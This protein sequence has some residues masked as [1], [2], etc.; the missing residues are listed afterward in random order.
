MDWRRQVV[1]EAENEYGQSKLYPSENCNCSGGPGDASVS[2]AVF[3]RFRTRMH[4][5]TNQSHILFGDLL[6]S[7]RP[8]RMH[9][10]EAS[11]RSEKWDGSLAHPV[12]NSPTLPS[13]SPNPPFHSLP[14]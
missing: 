4:A 3:G 11:E 13:V 12:P 7:F 6:N 8:H 14:S 1:T 2:P 5:I 10:T 9:S